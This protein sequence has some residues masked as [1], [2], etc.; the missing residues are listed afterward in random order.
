M[1]LGVAVI[2]AKGKSLGVPYKCLQ[3]IGGRTLVARSV[4]QAQK[5]KHIDQIFVVTEDEG[6]ADEAKRSGA[7]VFSCTEGMSD[8]TTMVWEKVRMVAKSFNDCRGG[9]DPFFVELH[10]TY[11]FRKPELIDQA[12]NYLMEMDDADSVIVGS[13]LFDRVWR[14]Y[15]EGFKR[16]ASDIEIKA[17]Q[18]Q[19]PLYLDHYGLC[20]V[21]THESAL[22]GNPYSGKLYLMPCN[23]KR[24]LLDID[25]QE[26]LEMCQAIAGYMP[27][28]IF[29]GV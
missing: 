5:A 3:A 21:S 13:F 26:D 24:Q 22:R 15:T 20:N 6:V 14:R 16:L 10:P 18:E 28:R 29:G 1:S 2:P 8:N 17:R 9:I 11:P 25:D 23:D 19:I 4:E 27:Y 7:T 12:I